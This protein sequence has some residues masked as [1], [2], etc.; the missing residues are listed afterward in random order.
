MLFRSAPHYEIA[1]YFDDGRSAEGL[2]GTRVRRKIADSGL[3]NEAVTLEHRYV[4][5]DAA[6]GLSLLES[7]ARTVTVATPATSG[8]LSLF[9][10]LLG[11]DLSGRGRALEHLGLGDLSRREILSLLVDGWTSPVWSRITR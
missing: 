8:L 11:R 6:L 9:A 5:E 4:T 2:Y 3:W 10:V 1:T 7:A